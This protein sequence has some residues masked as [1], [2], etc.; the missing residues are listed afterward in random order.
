MK[1]TRE[2]DGIPCD[3]VDTGE[4]RIIHFGQQMM[5]RMPELVEQR[6]DV[7]E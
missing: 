5:Q 2:L 7:V 1:L 4:R 6:D 3:A